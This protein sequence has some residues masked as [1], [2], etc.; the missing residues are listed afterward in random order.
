MGRRNLGEDSRR[1]P[2]IHPP[3]RERGRAPVRSLGHL[4]SEPS[5]GRVRAD[6]N[7]TFS[8]LSE[9]TRRAMLEE[10]TAGEMTVGELSKPFGGSFPGLPHN[11]ILSAEAGPLTGATA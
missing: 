2:Q 4:R 6:L 5:P 7:R 11:L 8:A 3:H 9:P 10:L 1:Q